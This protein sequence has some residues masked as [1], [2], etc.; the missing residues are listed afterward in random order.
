M[1]KELLIS[2]LTVLSIFSLAAQPKPTM[3]EPYAAQ[4]KAIDSLDQ[5][6]LYRSALTETESLLALVRTRDL[7]AQTVRAL[8]YRAKYSREINENGNDLAINQL[9]EELAKATFPEKPLLQTFLAEAYQNYLQQNRWQIN[10]RTRLGTGAE[11]DIANWS[12]QDFIERATTLYLNSLDDARTRQL[13]LE[14]VSAMVELSDNADRRPTLYDLLAFRAIDYFA[15]G[16]ASLTAAAYAF[17]IDDAVFFA[18]A[19]TFITHTFSAADTT[20]AL[21]RMVR[22]YQQL[23]AFHANETKNATAFVDAD[24]H[25]L[26]FVHAESTLENKNELYQ[27]ALEALR[28][29]YRGQ[30]VEADI[31]LALAQY[32]LQRGNDYST[33]KNQE[34][35][36]DWRF[37]YSLAT[38][39]STRF[40]QSKA[41][42]RAANV[43]LQLEA[44][45][46]SLQVEQVYLPEQ[47]GLFQIG[48]RNL[49]TLYWR[50]VR[51]D[52]TEI[53]RSEDDEKKQKRLMAREAVSVGTQ[54][55]TEVGDYR[56]HTTELY[57]QMLPLGTYGLIVSDNGEFSDEKG[58]VSYQ[59]F[60]VSR[61]G[62]LVLSDSQQ[63]TN[64]VL[65]TD[66]ETGAPLPGV[67]VEV[68][69]SPDGRNGKRAVLTTARTN[70]QGRAELKTGNSRYGQLHLR[71]G[72]D[73]LYASDYVYS[74]GN[75]YQQRPRQATEFFLDRGIYRP[76]QT[77]Y[78]KALLLEYDAD[79]FP[80]VLTNKAV[81]IMLRDVN[82]QEVS[83]LSLQS[84]EY[85]SVQ[86]VFTLPSDG[87]TGQMQITSTVGG[88]SR[89]VQVE[90]YKRPR[91]VV[92]MEDLAGRPRLGE[93]VTVTGTAEAYAGPV[94]QD[95]TVRYSVTRQSYVPWWYARYY[96]QA[97][98]T[99]QIAAGTTTTDEEGRFS[100][101]FAA[102]DPD[103]KP[104]GRWRP[105]YEYVVQ[106]DVTD[107]TGETRSAEKRMVLSKTGIQLSVEVP[108]FQDRGDELAVRVTAN[109][110]DGKPVPIASVIKAVR[111]GRPDRV[112]V[113]RYW[114]QPDQPVIP[115]AEFLRNFPNFA[116][117]DEDEMIK[118]P[119]LNE[120]YQQ[121]LTNANDTLTLRTLDWPTGVY[122]LTVET[123]DGET[124][125][126]YLTLYDKA[127]NIPPV[128]EILWVNTEQTTYQ[129]GETATIEMATAAGNLVAATRLA[130]RTEER[131][132]TWL[133]IN[134][135]QTLTVTLQ[136]SDRGG[137]VG[138]IN[139]VRYNRYYSQA[140][141]LNVPWDNKKLSVRYETFRDKL[142][143]GVPEE[144]R[145]VIEGP[146]GE[147]VTAEIVAAMYDAS[148]DQLYP[149]SWDFSPY[150][151]AY[152]S[153]RWSA[154]TFGTNYGW[155]RGQQTSGYLVPPVYPSLRTFN[156]FNQY[157]GR[158]YMALSRSS[159]PMEEAGMAMD[160]MSAPDSAPP[161]PP[162][163]PGSSAKN[164]AEEKEEAAAESAGGDISPRKNLQE[165][166]FFFPQLK[167]D[168]QGRTILSFTT[169]E[170]LT[171]W[172]VQLFGHTPELAYTL[173][174][175][176]VVTQK[177]LMILPNAPRFLREGDELYFTAKVS[178]T[179]D[180]LLSGQAKLEIFSAT[181]MQPVS[182]K[183]E[184]SGADQ[185]FTLK[186]G[187]SQGMSWR[188]KVPDGAA[189]AIVYRVTAR[190]GN[191]GDGEEA[192]IPVLTN[193]TMLTAAIPLH[194]G[195]RETR[196]FTLDPLAR[197]AAGDQPQRVTL[198][199]T[200]NPAWL[201]IKSLPYLME[202][203]YNCTEQ[204]VN[205]FY[206]NSLATQVV[207]SYPKT[208]QIFEQWRASATSLESP[209]TL[210]QELAGI[211]L[212]E[213]P[214]VRDAQSEAE[215]R[216]RIAVLFDLDRMAKEQT[217]ALKDLVSRQKADGGF[218]WF[219][220]GETSWYMTQYVLESLY[221]LRELKVAT[222]QQNQ[223]VQ[224]LTRKALT[225]VNKQAKEHYDELTKEVK[226]KR[227]TWEDDHLD[228]RII[229]YLYVTSFVDDQQ[230]FK[231]M[232][233]ARL[234]F[235]DQADKYWLEKGLYEQGM[236]ALALNRS[237]RA[238]TAGTIFRSLRERALQ[239]EEL[240]MYWKYPR[241]FY[242]NQLPIET[243]TMLL[244][245]FNELGG[246]KEEIE[247]LKIWL[248]KNKETNRWETTKGTAA[249]VYALLHT[250][251]DWLGESQLVQATFPNADKSLY[252]A[253]ISEAENSAE[254]G[255]GYY[256]TQWSAEE[257]TSALGTVK[258]R[259]RNQT[260]AW[261]GLYYQY[262]RDI[263]KV[264]RFSDSPLKIERQIYRRDVGDRG[265]TLTE[266]TTG[267]D[268]E[269]G[270]RLTVRLLVQTDRDMEYVHL[271]DL[272]AS[273]MEPTETLSGYRYQDALGYYQSI[274]DV[275]MHYFFDYLP[276][277]NYVLEY[278]L[279]VNHRGDFSNGVATLQ[280]MYAPSFSAYSKGSR[281]RV[282]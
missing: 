161:P 237:G 232:A 147:A 14:Q 84:N 107:L 85:G 265:E 59:Y 194:I 35:Q 230:V 275:G 155:G 273:G 263:D 268:L 245:V 192:A 280:C 153:G 159:A 80:R 165:T 13:S 215:Q 70:A 158:Q 95:A 15:T 175:R 201:A 117:Q 42:A 176:E 243:H 239:S 44:K 50:I 3:P 203:P 276:K 112:F 247:Q 256:R 132:D 157:G 89:A 124:S 87:L 207:N 196:S 81:T 21:Y 33:E 27:G 266:I 45:N 220:G 190:S 262:L 148:L 106:A 145:I 277:G 63:K 99:L 226:A 183:Y 122:R 58:Q 150:P 90:E 116:Y 257:I 173:D 186:P 205:R 163:P 271:K 269:P 178:N 1:I 98:E 278:D 261:G 74:Q 75:G 169:P 102:L 279:F 110:A 8:I 18:P 235:L 231:D 25:R 12:T 28:N 187:A 2:L 108:R 224:Q 111:L 254:A 127:A 82:G 72:E 47:A 123:T 260:I 162:S 125:E 223:E 97:G 5:K 252:A 227:T 78:F 65:V 281:I 17:Q 129:P 68:I 177:E 52:G 10:E 134:P 151:R 218:S 182:T 40:A 259:N 140:L 184:L 250:G 22:I 104:T 251:D 119:V 274:T 86:G 38:E 138:Q 229:H 30:V 264:E 66:R 32:F 37:A 206:A 126:A 146:E 143:P 193:K 166:A 214:W 92:E 51:V 55:L 26:Q 24:L 141:Q 16:E 48:Y 253:R 49:E 219:P 168:R 54:R 188:L 139:A 29:Q 4:W 246:T 109:N 114:E 137:M 103:N 142:K 236:L 118:W 62:P 202:Y 88:D 76:S 128:G 136:E 7:P 91:F 213:T 100:I 149:Y 69:A 211:V 34:R 133:N 208:R 255:T 31:I 61:L 189:G 209:L 167:T 221:H 212:E 131:V 83:S 57:F 258:L 225:F 105:Q 174:T 79:N 156:F 240:G 185:P 46:L 56:Q 191:F 233:Q 130:N 67:E 234:Y 248:L 73:E 41:A 60:T 23:L 101:S 53:A 77:V 267:K 228:S 241:G 204:L 172:K 120:V 171:R 238:A 152:N 20:A 244:E 19:P 197:L 195:G 71:F 115:Q 181:D 64:E 93:T 272:R 200:S 43:Q 179:S 154:N 113:D 39:V 199:I 180:K 198:E 144:W 164:Q 96:A 36:F 121:Q 135:W 222:W 9:E 216:Q 217:A 6:G 282:E 160:V 94:L 249:A 170:A 270:Q 11:D 242:W 210:N